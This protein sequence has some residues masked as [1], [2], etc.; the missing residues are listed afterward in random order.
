MHNFSAMGNSQIVTAQF[1]KISSTIHASFTSVPDG[2]GLTSVII[3]DL[4]FDYC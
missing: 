3:V 2:V 4:L 1:A